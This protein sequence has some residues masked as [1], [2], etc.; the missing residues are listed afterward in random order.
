MV[1]FE[2]LISML[3]TSVLSNVALSRPL[4]LIVFEYG[5]LNIDL[6]IVNFTIMNR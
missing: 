1:D 6:V 5:S 2:S 4:E 3:M